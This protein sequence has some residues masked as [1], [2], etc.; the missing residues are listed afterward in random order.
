[1][2]I[3][4][5]VKYKKILD[6]SVIIRMTNLK[7]FLNYKQMYLLA[8]NC[9][10]VYPLLHAAAFQASLR[11]QGTSE[12]QLYNGIFMPAVCPIRKY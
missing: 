7:S 11:V 2:P 12:W 4:I 9:A 6:F 3:C 8:R 1:M 10:F 5:S